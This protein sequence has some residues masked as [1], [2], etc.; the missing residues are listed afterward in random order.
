MGI[1][2]VHAVLAF[3]RTARQIPVALHS[4]MRAMHIVAGLPG[5]TLRTERLNS[6]EIDRPSVG[7]PKP[8][9][10]VGMMAAEARKLA[11]M[12]RESLMELSELLARI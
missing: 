10:I 9:V 1:V 4:S 5:M 11:V 2:A 7:K 8:I 12:K 3:A 6:F